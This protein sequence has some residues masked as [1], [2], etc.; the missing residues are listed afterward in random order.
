ME[1]IWVR[2]CQELF[3]LHL[4]LLFNRICIFIWNTNI[5]VTNTKANRDSCHTIGTTH[6]SESGHEI[7]TGWC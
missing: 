2:P 5:S 1:F 3:S 6:I 4:I 7:S